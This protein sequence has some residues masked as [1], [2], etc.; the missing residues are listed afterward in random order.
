MTET[1]PVDDD[2]TEGK[3]NEFSIVFAIIPAVIVV[4]LILVI[5]IFLMMRKK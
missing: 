4:L 3:E 1:G 5:T 2:D